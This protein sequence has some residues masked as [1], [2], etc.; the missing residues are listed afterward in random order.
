MIWNPL[1]KALYY[2]RK[3]NIELAQLK[4]MILYASGQKICIIL[5]TNNNC[6]S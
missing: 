1:F 3:L 2:F 4:N 5:H 6:Y